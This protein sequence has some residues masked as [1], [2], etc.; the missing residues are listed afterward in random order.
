MLCPMCGSNPPDGLCRECIDQRIDN[1]CDELRRTWEK[2]IDQIVQI[3]QSEKHHFE[4]GGI[5]P[6]DCSMCER[7]Q[8]IANKIH[9][10]RDS[11][12]GGK[13]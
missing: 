3:I 2:R 13:E 5:G 9:V 8:D 11:S 10:L 6:C 4:E 12:K 1:E 7:L